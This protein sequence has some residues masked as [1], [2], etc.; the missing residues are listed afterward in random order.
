MILLGGTWAD[1]SEATDSCW[2][3]PYTSQGPGGCTV[4]GGHM[5]PALGHTM[6]PYPC[7]WNLAHSRFS[8]DTER[9]DGRESSVCMSATAQ[10]DGLSGCGPGLGVG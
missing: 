5:G 1:P 10:Q 2:G 7:V 6:K 8:T 4:H 9:M 3:S